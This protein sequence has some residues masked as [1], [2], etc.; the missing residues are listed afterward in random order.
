MI[1]IEEPCI[2]ETAGIVEDPIMTPD[3]YVEAFNSPLTKSVM[4]DS[5]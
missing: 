3:F 1:Q 2:H 5:I 4:A